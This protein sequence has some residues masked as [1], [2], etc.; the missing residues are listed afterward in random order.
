MERRRRRVIVRIL[1]TA[2]ASAF[3]LLGLY[4]VSS[5]Q[6]EPVRTGGGVASVADEAPGRL[7]EDFN[8]PQ[9]D[10]ILAERGFVLKRGDGHI[11]LAD[12]VS[13]TGQLELL[14]RDQGKVCFDVTGDSGWLTME[15][16]A[17]FSF[18]GNDY[19]TT[20]D[21]TVG[22][23]EKS[24]DITKNTWTPV[25]ESTDPESRDH[26]LIEIRTTK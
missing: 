1:G 2:G 16:P 26:A 3:V 12:C 5:G 20:I 17:V 25:G 14:A 10:K 21:M 13:G 9:A 11:A 19:S 7:V 4:A 23:E 22:E 15:I 6:G 18:K 24:F 8:Y